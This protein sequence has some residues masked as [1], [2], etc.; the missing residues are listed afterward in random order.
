MT[1][2]IG[3][4]G[5]GKTNILEAI[6]LF[7]PGRGLRGAETS[8]LQMQYMGLAAPKPQSGEGG[9][10]IQL[11]ISDEN[12]AVQLSTGVAPGASRRSVLVGGET[13]AQTDLRDYLTILWL[14]P[15]DDFV[16][17][18]GTTSRRAFLDRLTGALDPQH[19][20]RIQQLQKSLSE[21]LRVLAMP[22]AN[23]V[24]LT[25]LE[26]EIAER[27]TAI[28]AARLNFLEQLTPHL[29]A[30]SPDFPAVH[31]MIAGEVE[32]TLQSTPALQVEENYAAQLFQSRGDDAARGRTAYG[33]HRSDWRITHQDK[34]Q[35]AERCSTGEQKA[36]L[37]SLF[38]ATTT[39]VRR[40]DGRAPTLLLDEC[41]SHLDALRIKTLLEKLFQTDAQ[42]FLTATD[43]ALIRQ[44]PDAGIH[45]LNGHL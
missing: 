23:G 7:A 10:G 16:L 3:P 32:T 28:A 26:K 5:S 18:Q 41:L 36:I 17:A 42:I 37:F 30:F 38:L 45:S 27:G 11:E 13:A 40:H 25:A 4:N 22:R 19:A 21:R 31:S 34:H 8:E 9:W 1:A 12:S 33:A 44:F 6:S 20:G 24:W 35:P 39:L 14:T 29:N 2:I 43:D 15:E